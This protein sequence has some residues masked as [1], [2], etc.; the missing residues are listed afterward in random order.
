[1]Q[2]IQVPDFSF[3]SPLA[4]V[5]IELERLRGDLGTSTTPQ[6]VF[7]QLK[8]LFQ[9]MTSIMSARIEGNRTSIVEVVEGASEGTKLRNIPNRHH[10]HDSERSKVSDG[11]KEIMLLEDAASFIDEHVRPGTPITHALVRELHKISVTGLVR[12]GD[13]TPGSYRTSDVVI[14]GSAHLPPAFI[15]V[16]ADMQE[17]LDFINKEDDSSFD[18]LKVA[19]AHHRFVWIHPFGNG[20]GRTCRLLTYAIMVSQG[21]TTTIGYRAIDP[22]AVFGADRSAYYQ[23]LEAADSLEPTAIIG[24]CTY[25]LSG[26]LDDLKKLSRLGDHAFVIDKLL[27]PSFLR[28]VA[29]GVIDT[30][31]QAAL[32]VVANKTII[33]ASDLSV[34]FSG[35]DVARS[36]FIRRLIERRL[37]EPVAEGKRTYRLVMSPGPLTPF[38]F[39]QLDEL[40]FLPQILRDE[41]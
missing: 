10:K 6:P 36:Q 20:N 18:L 9:L 19:I 11:V 17:L 12:E 8:Q 15:A 14:Q 38:I 16:Q 21:F 4:K 26:M 39:R 2:P 29:A 24:W 28:T 31:E 25:L 37:I 5:V 33:K 30:R 13:R 41:V 32:D 27:K 23:N 35:T 3:N 34:M 7:L 1:M 40:G 22:T